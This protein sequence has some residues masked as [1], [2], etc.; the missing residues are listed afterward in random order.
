MKKLIGQLKGRLHSINMRKR[1]ENGKSLEQ[2]GKV[3]GR[4][5]QEGG[6]VFSGIKLFPWDRACFSMVFDSG[7]GVDRGIWNFLRDSGI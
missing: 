6:R 5:T 2:S 3:P 7:C 1:W 4:M